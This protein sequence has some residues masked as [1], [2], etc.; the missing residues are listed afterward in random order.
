MP[1]NTSVAAAAAKQGAG[2]RGGARPKSEWHIA[3]ALT[4]KQALRDAADRILKGKASRD[5]AALE[6]ENIWR[7]AKAAGAQSA[8]H[9]T[10]WR[11][12]DVIE[13]FKAQVVKLEADAEA[14]LPTAVIGRLRKDLA[15][16]RAT[17][18]TRIREMEERIN[19][20]AQ[21]V[22]LLTLALRT[23]PAKPTDGG[24]VGDITG[25]VR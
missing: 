11:H 2:Q 4:T 22:Q 7:E 21:Q 13:Y 15:E 9:A 8:S 1:T 18:G 10:L 19:T 20:L 23:P 5:Y 16:L 12:P 24:V 6:V 14:T 25:G 17:S 3:R